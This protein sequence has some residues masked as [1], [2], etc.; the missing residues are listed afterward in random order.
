MQ[1]LQNV[2]EDLLLIPQTSQNQPSVFDAG[3]GSGELSTE[4]REVPHFPQN[5]ES[6]GF[7]SPQESQLKVIS[8]FSPHDPQN[9]EPSG[10]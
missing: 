3:F 2:D 10:L 9:G 7:S 8:S 1:A 4:P 5:R 6:S